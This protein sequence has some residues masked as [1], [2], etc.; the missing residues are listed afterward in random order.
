MPKTR[1]NTVRIVNPL[2]GGAQYTSNRSA[3]EFVR[4]G[5]AVLD[6][7]GTAIRFLDQT[8]RIHQ[9]QRSDGGD[10]QFRWRLGKTG[11]MVQ[12]IGSIVYPIAHEGHDEEKPYE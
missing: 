4:R 5:L 9:A 3:S 10:S 1:H 11:G 7:E 2:P 12:R 8:R 6:G